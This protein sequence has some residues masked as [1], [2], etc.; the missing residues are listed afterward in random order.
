MAHL[1]PFRRVPNRGL[2]TLVTLAG[3]ATAQAGTL[4]GRVVDR[5]NQAWVQGAK[6]VV[7]GVGKSD[8]EATATTNAYGRYSVVIAT[9]GKYTLV[10]SGA[11]FG[12]LEVPDPVNLTE[13]GR[14]IYQDVSLTRSGAFQEKGNGVPGALSWQTGAGKSTAIPALE[15]PLFQFG[16]N[17]IDRQLYPHLMEDGRKVY[18][19]TWR[20]TYAHITKGPWVV[21]QDAFSMNQFMHPYTGSVYFGFAR[22][23][24]QSFWASTAY[25][26]L[27]IVWLVPGLHAEK[28]TALIR[29]LPKASR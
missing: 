11:G 20:T 6:V 7:K 19:S 27:L 21:D 16:L 26:V 12:D 17:Q 13:E 2:A 3:C 14:E 15:I 23:A 1:S 5:T 22:S 9:P 18:S 24:G 10:V 28:A 8:V 25:T 4:S 29:G